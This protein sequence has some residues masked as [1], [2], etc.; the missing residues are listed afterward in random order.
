[1]AS[2]LYITAPVDQEIFQEDEAWTVVTTH[3]RRGLWY[4]YFKNF[5]LN[6]LRSSE[7]N[8][9]RLALV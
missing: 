7:L 2:V 9:V 3:I 8:L 4:L 5:L 6:F 1:M